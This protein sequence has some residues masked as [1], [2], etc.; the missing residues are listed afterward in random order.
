MDEQ[1]KIPQWLLWAREIQ[2]LSQTGYHYAQNE[3]EAQR[4]A[5]LREIAAEIIANY[6]SL[7]T[8][9]LVQEFSFQTLKS[10]LLFKG[11][12]FKGSYVYT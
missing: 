5:R 3:F 10:Q 1:Q 11:A 7:E 8:T 9:D 12:S 4:H 2:A 6:S